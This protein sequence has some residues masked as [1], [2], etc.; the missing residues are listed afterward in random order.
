MHIMDKRGEVWKTIIVMVPIL[1]ATLIA[2]SRIMDARHHP[3]D[4]ITGSLLG[5]FTA[6][7]S[8]RQYFPSL[9]EPWK[10]GRAYPIRSWA[11]EPKIPAGMSDNDD[12]VPLRD[13]RGVQMYAQGRQADLSQDFSLHPESQQNVPGGGAVYR[14]KRRDRDGYSSSSSEDVSEGFEMTAPRGRERL[15]VSAATTSHQPYD[16]TYYSP[17]RSASPGNIESGVESRDLAGEI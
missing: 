4:V 2:V 1:A 16:T 11:T 8:Y 10:K 7:A 17:G 12:T 15:N 9:S 14:A 5:V 13:E 3:F 6:W